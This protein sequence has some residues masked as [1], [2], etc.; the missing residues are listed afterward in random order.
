VESYTNACIKNGFELIEYK[1]LVQKS[2][3]PR[4]INRL[5]TIKED[6]LVTLQKNTNYMPLIVK[7]DD[8]VAN[9]F[10]RQIEQWL[11]N[12][13][14]IDTNEIFLRIMKK[15]FSDKLI[16]GNVD[17]LK[18]LTE[19][20]VFSEQKQWRLKNDQIELQTA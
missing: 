12:E 11:L 9:M 8:E 6:V 3:T 14:R 16:I 5:K 2:F 18:V 17:L 19:N 20:F 10:K 13:K 7:S 1:W 4:Q 15:V